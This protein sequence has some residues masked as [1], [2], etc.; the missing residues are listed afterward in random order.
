MKL[1]EYKTGKNVIRV[2]ILAGSVATAAILAISAGAQA[3][4]IQWTV[5]AGG[6]DHWYDFVPQ[7]SLTTWD[8]ARADALAMTNFGMSGYLATVT[9]D[10]ENSFLANMVDERVGYL[11]G[12][13]EAVEDEWRW[14]DGPEAGQQFSQGGAATAPDNYV[15][16]NGGEPNDKDGN[17]HVLHMNFDV[18]GG[19]NDTLPGFELTDGYFVEFDPV[20][21]PATLA[22][23]GLGLA[24]LG[25][26]RRR[27]AT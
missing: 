16:W 4:P 5:G 22:L 10:A 1:G 14:I 24:G 27:R 18:S 21:E 2:S 7:G 26:M 12:T 3:A 17:E 23:F 19:W 15:N 25:F 11:G 9:S 6:N 8:E 20:S 13:D